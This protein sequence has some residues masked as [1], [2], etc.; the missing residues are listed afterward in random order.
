MAYVLLC[1]LRRTTLDQT[2]FANVACG[3]ICL[4]LLEIGTLVRFGVR[5]VSCMG[6]AIH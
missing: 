5:R 1:A 4:K 6:S 2:H 3:T